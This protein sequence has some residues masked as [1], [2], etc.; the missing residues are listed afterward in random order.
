MLPYTWQKHQQSTA[1]WDSLTEW[2]S[3][4]DLN[5]G[6]GGRGEDLHGGRHTAETTKA[7]PPVKGGWYEGPGG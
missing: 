7:G 6:R 4:W 5:E 3:C 2:A 1:Q